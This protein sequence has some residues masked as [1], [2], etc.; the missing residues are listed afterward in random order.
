M[1]NF[2]EK[3][4][5]TIDSDKIIIERLKKINRNEIENTN[6]PRLRIYKNPYKKVE[7]TE[8]AY[9][10]I[11]F[12][13]EKYVP[14]LFT[15]G[16]SLKRTNTKNNLVCLIQDKSY[17]LEDGTI[18][19]GLS[20][21]IKKDLFKIYD[22]VIGIDLLYIED[23]KPPK[24]H[25]TERPS[26]KNIK[27][28]ITKLNVLGLIQY[29]KIIFLDASSIVKSNLDDM[30]KKYDKSVFCNDYE[31]KETNVGLKGS[32]YIYKPN[33]YYFKKSI[34][35]INN[36]NQIFGDLF[37]IRGID[38]ILLYYTIYP[39]WSNNLLENNLSCSATKKK[40]C[41]NY[42]IIYY[43]NI[44]PF[45]EPRDKIEMDIIKNHYK[46]YNEWDKI[47]NIVIENNPTLKIYFD[48]II[49]RF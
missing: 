29:K 49:K 32:V 41:D 20:D 28:Y 21:K 30:F 10:T 26:Y 35:L 38:E 4:R 42:K 44:K 45:I 31:Y 23:Y 9:V 24:N 14:S 16:E 36:Y 43:Q 8:Y 18:I 6:I 33:I 3:K 7:L 22:Y 17:K 2:Y 48:S 13:N 12:I 37:F 15:L 11:I 46:N 19:Q 27:F 1:S 47:M 34:Y 40:N 25:F 5:L 39:E